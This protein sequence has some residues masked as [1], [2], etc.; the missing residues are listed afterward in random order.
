MHRIVNLTWFFFWIG[1]SILPQFC[2]ALHIYIWLRLGISINF[3]SKRRQEDIFSALFW[4]YCFTHAS[5]NI[6]ADSCE[7]PFYHRLSS[8][9][10]ILLRNFSL[11]CE[12]LDN[13]AIC[14]PNP[15]AALDILG[16]SSYS[17]TFMDAPA[18]L[19]HCCSPFWTACCLVQ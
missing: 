5:I 17:A 10:H 14:D 8:V 2:D 19:L 18:L 1:E 11:N 13:P 9:A 3:L 7:N 15:N 6:M 12:P 4:W 16:F